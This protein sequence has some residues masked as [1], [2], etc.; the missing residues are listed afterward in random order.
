MIERVAVIVPAADEQ[1]RISA[2]LRAIERARRRLLDSELKVDRV[3]VFVVLDGCRD[4]TPAIV[5]RFAA[6]NRVRAVTSTARRVG[7]AR[8][9]GALRAIA[10]LAPPERLWLANTDA[11]ST[12]PGDWLTGMVTAAN[13]GA[14][15]VLG[16]VLPDVELPRALRAAWRA[17]HH[18]HDGHPH[19]HGA[20]LGIRAD[21]YLALGG[22]RAD[23]AC[24]E[25]VDLAQRAVSVAD[26]R[27][28]RTAAIPVVTSARMVG[29]APDG[30]SSYLRHLRDHRAV[31]SAVAA[32]ESS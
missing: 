31:A 22:W 5:A 10:S 11:D 28:L 30:F 4:N 14:Q 29:Q 27:I 1:D 21:T 32:E 25:D 20:N 19:V 8:R 23:L 13:A 18:L 6:T 24:D 7:A 2:C 26:I 15:V 3:D 9:R 12:V 17:Q 16:T